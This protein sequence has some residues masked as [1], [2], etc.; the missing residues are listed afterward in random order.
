MEKRLAHNDYLQKCFGSHPAALEN[1]DSYTLGRVIMKTPHKHQVNTKI[2][3]KELNTMVVNA[4]WKM[5]PHTCPVYL[6]E[7]EDWFHVLVFRSPDMMRI[8]EGVMTDLMID[9]DRFKTY[10][11]CRLYY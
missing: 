7:V 3:H 9:M 6:N 2:I 5:G 1:V 10:P 4:R 8:R 11:P